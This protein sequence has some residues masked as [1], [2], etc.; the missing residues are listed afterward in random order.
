MSRDL[1]HAPHPIWAKLFFAFGP[2]FF[3]GLEKAWPTPRT[4]FGP[5]PHHPATINHNHIHLG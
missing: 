5:A 4:P 2:D 1:A 3:E